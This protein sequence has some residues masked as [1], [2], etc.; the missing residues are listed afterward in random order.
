LLFHYK[1]ARVH[2]AVL[3]KRAGPGTAPLRV[4]S[5]VRGRGVTIGNRPFRAQQRAWAWLLAPEFHSYDI[6]RCPRLY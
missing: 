4:W 1:D 3:K 5:L 6:F 2:C